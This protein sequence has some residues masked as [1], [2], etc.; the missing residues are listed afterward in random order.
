MTHQ[1]ELCGDDIIAISTFQY[2]SLLDNDGED[3]M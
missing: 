1:V 2:A 3:S